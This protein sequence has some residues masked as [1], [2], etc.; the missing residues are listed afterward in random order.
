MKPTRLCRRIAFTL[1]ELLV[2]IA[3]IGLLMAMLVPAIQKV[4]AAAALTQC[5]NNL[6]QMGLAFHNYASANR[7]KFPPR[8]CKAGTVPARGWGPYLLPSLDGSLAAGYDM[9]YDLWDPVN[10]PVTSKTVPTFLCPATPL[11][12]TDTYP[13]TG[14]GYATAASPN[15]NNGQLNSS[16]TGGR[17]DYVASNGIAL[18]ASSVV[19]AGWTVASPSQNNQAMFDEVPLSLKLITDGL[20]NTMLLTEEAGRPKAFV[21]GFMVTPDIAPTAPS[22]SYSATSPS[23]AADLPTRGMWAGSNV[24]AFTIYP[25]PTPP[26]IP[27]TSGVAPDLQTCAINCY[28]GNGIYSFHSG[29]ANL[30]LCD[31]SVRFMSAD[32]NLRTLAQLCTRND[33]ESMSGY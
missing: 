7:N 15:Y 26:A 5:A 32:I 24:A 16:F 21:A 19:G 29:G 10:Q 14:Y 13:F 6:K 27:T 4:R 11:S 2:V 33:G 3:I 23:A 28:N 30:L 31:G 22:A 20:S 12:P 18:S 1:I 8:R 17:S 9:R 25:Q